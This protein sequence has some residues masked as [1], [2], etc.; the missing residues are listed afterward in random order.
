MRDASGHRML[1]IHYKLT[2]HGMQGLAYA[3]PTVLLMMYGEQQA[4]E[5]RIW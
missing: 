5:S 4:K 3:L 1:L 2:R